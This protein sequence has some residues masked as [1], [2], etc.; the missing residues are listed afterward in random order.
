MGACVTLYRD[1]VFSASEDYF[2]IASLELKAAFGAG[3]TV[4]R[5]GSDIGTITRP[6]LDVARVARECAERPIV[7]VKHLTVERGLL[8]ARAGPDLKM[9]SDTASALAKE[10]PRTI[11]VQT[12]VSGEASTAF[13]SAE[14]FH[15][16]SEALSSHGFKVH[17]SGQE[18][19]L[20]CCV[21]PK[22]V[23]IG[24][25]KTRNSICDWPGGRVRY[26]RGPSQV[27]RAEFK[28]EE[29]LAAFQV[30]LPVDGVALDL[31]AAPGGWTRI[32]RT[33]GLRVVSV[34]PGDL[35]PT[36]SDD[37]GVRHVR[38]TAADF[39]K[40]SR[41][42]FDVVL[43]DMRMFPDMSCKLMVRAMR[44]LT[45]AGFG[46]ITLKI[47][48]RDATKL[49]SESLR[50]LSRDYVIVGARQLHHNRSEVTVVLQ[51]P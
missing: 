25:N 3:L 20:S 5:L 4:T 29:A 50:V 11:S 33:H 27:S 26:S 49:V 9:L 17:R 44:S 16:L 46:I 37:P 34:D 28:L 31:G 15:V 39:L 32:M 13:G 14:I 2:E 38:T 36:I 8:P 23:L 19:V 47:S 48:S 30:T 21:T 40:S 24:A 35:D 18:Y 10:L 7:F 43:N 1:I 41:A 22:G 45:P 6:G 51:R 42:S 12:W